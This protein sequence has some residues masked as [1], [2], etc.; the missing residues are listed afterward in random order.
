[1]SSRQVEQKGL[2]GALFTEKVID[3]HKSKFY[4]KSE[5]PVHANRG[6]YKPQALDVSPVVFQ[7]F[8]QSMGRIV[9]GKTYSLTQRRWRP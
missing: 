6:G 3:D 8:C 1:M 9:G 4:E 5:P 2:G 7:S